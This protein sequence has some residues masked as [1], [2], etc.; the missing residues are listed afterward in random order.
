MRFAYS[1]LNAA[2]LQGGSV[3]ELLVN[4][5][6]DLE[7]ADEGGVVY[8]ERAFPVV[9]LARELVAWIQS[10]CAKHEDFQLTSLSFEEKGVVRIVH[11]PEGWLVGS[12]FEPDLFS[13]PIAWKELSQSVLGFAANLRR[14]LGELGVGAWLIPDLSIGDT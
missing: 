11:S 14:D 10:A 2:D 7:I 1:N 8:A 12:V 3:A 5:E 13:R 6:A 9:E 4:L